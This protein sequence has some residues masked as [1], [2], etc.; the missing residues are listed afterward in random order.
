MTITFEFIVG[1]Y[2]IGHPWSKL[3][4]DYNILKGRVWSLILLT[5]LAGPY[6][7]GKHLTKNCTDGKHAK[8][9]DKLS[10]SKAQKKSFVFVL[11]LNFLQSM[12]RLSFAILGINV[13][14]DKFLDASVSHMT[15]SIL[16]M[17]FLVLGT[18]GLIATYGLW[19]RQRWGLWAITF[20]SLITIIFDIWGVTI[21][22]TAAM[23]FIV[24]VVSMGYLYF[25][26]SQLFAGGN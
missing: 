13:G 3:L 6:F 21:Q 11:V 26:K 24:P 16:H 1:H 7:I 2:I 5:I 18:S 22:A 25:R 15:S 23:G 20:V 14:I 12:G 9:S 4:A 10:I 17:M 8:A 19:K